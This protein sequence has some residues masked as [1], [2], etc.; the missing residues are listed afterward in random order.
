MNAELEQAL[1]SRSTV[2]MAKG[3]LMARLGLDPDGAFDALRSISQR[4]HV[5]LRDL[6]VE[7][8]RER[9]A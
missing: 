1:V 8:V 4:R 6:A 9:K 3:I 7:L 2:D 5:K